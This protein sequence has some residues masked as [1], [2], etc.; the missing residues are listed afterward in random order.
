MAFVLSSPSCF[1]EK[2]SSPRVTSKFM[3]TTDDNYVDNLFVVC[4]SVTKRGTF[5][6]LVTS[7]NIHN[8]SHGPII[9]KS[10]W[11]ADFN[12]FSAKFA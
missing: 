12:V 1:N 5:S 11:S 4:L 6:C 8:A 9:V 2:S 7:V 3:A 10:Y